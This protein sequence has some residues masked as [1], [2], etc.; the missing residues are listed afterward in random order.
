MNWI[1]TS[2]PPLGGHPNPGRQPAS[3]RPGPTLKPAGSSGPECPTDTLPT[4]SAGA[5]AKDAPAASGA[6]HAR[7]RSALAKTFVHWMR[8]KGQPVPSAEAKQWLASQDLPSRADTRQALRSAQSMGEALCD[9]ARFTTLK[10]PQ[11]A[12][13]P[14]LCPHPDLGWLIVTG[15]DAQGLWRCQDAAGD[16]HDLVLDGVA[17]LHLN[18][19]VDSTSDAPA[20]AR[21][22]VLLEMRRNWLV[23]VEAAGLSLVLAVVAISISFYSM[24][25]Y[26]RVIPSQ[27]HDTLWVLTGGVALAIL[28]EWLLKLARAGLLEPKLKQLDVQISQRLMTRLASVRADQRPG[29][30]GTLASQMQSFEAV[31]GV[32][33]TSTLFLLFDLPMA[34]LFATVIGLIGGVWMAAPAV[35]LFSMTLLAGL[36]RMR[37]IARI[38]AAQLK[39]ASA[40][41]GLLVEAIEGTESIKGLGAQWRFDSRWAT[42]CEVNATHNLTI[43]HETDATAYLSAGLQQASYVSL[44]CIGAVLAIQ[45]E[46]TQGAIIACSILS[47]RVLSPLASIPGVLVQ[48]GNARASM[49]AL[50]AIFRLETDNHLIAR[51]VVP[52]SIRGEIVFDDVEFAYPG[53]KQALRIGSLRIA[54]GEKVGIIGTIGA[55]K[56]TLLSMACGQSK[57]SRGTVYLDGVDQQQIHAGWRSAQMAYCPQQAWLF[58]GT[59]RDNLAF[60]LADVSDEHIIAACQRTGLWAMVSAH[61]MGLDRPLTE[62]GRGLSGGQR[63]LV[64]LTRL[65]LA[66]RSVWLLDEPTSGMDDG[67]EIATVQLL[68]QQLKPASTLLLVTHRMSMLRLVDRVIV[69][70][71]QGVLLDGPRDQVLAQLQGRPAAANPTA[72]SFSGASATAPMAVARRVAAE[73]TATVASAT[74]ASNG[75]AAPSSAAA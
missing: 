16:R 23:F 24:Q 48:L 8:L 52:E 67:L 44:I 40:K 43:K 22:L 28:I 31:R 75:P 27:G 49:K 34:I 54:A 65:L 37:K 62:G 17:C 69:L 36:L 33:S 35:L 25:V 1:K 12:A 68:K 72:G 13:L 20:T 15:R 2:P 39:Q 66:D 46:L 64:A 41:T 30:V 61:P 10:Q 5:P 55:G 56:S 32:L 74:A 3:I 71:P 6:V 60:G 58:A 42:L 63:Q 47:G 19:D 21:Q 18:A 9:A 73:P 53:A 50:D 7:E 45:G 59:L 11:L 51:P 4:P 26:D 29:S 70:S 57:P 38:S 14:L